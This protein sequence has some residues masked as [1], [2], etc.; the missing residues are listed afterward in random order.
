MVAS[1]SARRLLDR[2]ANARVGPT[3]ADVARHGVLD[4][5]IGRL[6][7]ARK[8]CRS[9]HDLAR[10]AVA[11]LRDL[12]I[13]P[14]LLDPGARRGRADRL[15]GG[16]LGAADAVDRGDAGTRRLA[17]DMHRAG[18][19][20]RHAAAEF[21][22]GHAEHVAQHPEE[23]GIAVDIDAVRAAVDFDSE[24]HGLLSFSTR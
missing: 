10:L 20:Q 6:R 14:G 8:E 21:R 1:L 5:G 7:L 16:D 3:A 15:D 13:D 23:R 17:A 24:R 11:A 18:A 4:V 22:A 12:A 19:A 9:G 2:L